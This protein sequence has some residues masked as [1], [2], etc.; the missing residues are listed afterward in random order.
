MDTTAY[1]EAAGDANAL[2]LPA[3]SKKIAPEVRAKPQPGVSKAQ[4]RKLR[5]VAQ[6]KQRR[7][8]L[9]E[10]HTPLQMCGCRAQAPSHQAHRT[11]PDA[12]GRACLLQAYQV[13]QEHQLSEE[14]NKLLRPTAWRGQAL[15]KRQR[16]SRELAQGMMHALLR[17]EPA[18][19]WHPLG[20]TQSA[21][22][23]LAKLSAIPM[24]L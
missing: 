17:Q 2:L 15:S 4:Q 11:P 5:Q 22:E 1:R 16:L 14:Q 7:Q 10:V 8:Q 21:Q 23:H 20:L 12:D 24:M 3:S 9:A 18:W 19:L 6:E 13:L